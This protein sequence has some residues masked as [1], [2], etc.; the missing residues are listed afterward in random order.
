MTENPHL[1]DDSHQEIVSPAA[2]G[3][4]NREIRMLIFQDRI[5]DRGVVFALGVCALALVYTLLYAAVLP[6]FFISLAVFILAGLVGAS[7]F[8]WRFVVHY[9]QNYALKSQEL[10]SLLEARDLHLQEDRVK[11]MHSGLEC[12]FKELKAAEGLRLLHKLDHEYEQLVPVLTGGKESDLLSM[13]NLDALVKETYF[14]GLSVLQDVF[15]LERLVRTTDNAQLQSET[16]ELQKKA[17]VLRDD[18]EGRERLAQV[19]ER[20]Q[21]N[22]ERLHM[23]RKIKQRM[24]ELM[25]QAGRCEASLGKTRI[26]LAALKAEASEIGVSAVTDTLRKTIDR[27]RDVQ[28]ELKKMGY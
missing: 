8:L 28:N 9:Q 27:A 18:P 3:I 7:L 21:S 24:E 4:S 16:A 12:G 1:Q 10:L 5:Q 22:Q 19:N 13:S 6:G 26:Q 20:I 14:R 2:P 15:E 23:L 11:E 25:Y 17:A